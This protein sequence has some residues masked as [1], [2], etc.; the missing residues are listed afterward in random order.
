METLEY[1]TLCLTCLRP[2]KA[3]F[4]AC[5]NPFDTNFAFRILMHPKEARKGH[6]GTGRLTNFALNNCQIIIGED[7]DHNQEVQELLNS[8]NIFPMI[9]Y[10]GEESI[11]LS[12]SK[13]ETQSFENKTPLVFII[14][15]SWPCAKSM[16]RESKSLHS[17][18]RISFDSTIE[19]RFLIKHQPAKYC[20]STIESTY[21]LLGLLEQQ[22][23]ENIGAAKDSMIKA[24]DQLVKFHIKCASDPSMKHYDRKGGA[25]KDPSERKPSK[26]WEYREI[27]FD[28]KNYS[29]Q[30][31]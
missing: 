5:I 28:E 17:L 21:I 9:L 31:I 6:L 1:R 11:N 12:S 14:D 26:K 27:C 8:P 18:P 23:L 2:S 22:G 13:L 19:S 24:L 15:G 3:C 16:M 7:F 30:R 10:P 4:C 20:L 29:R 25:Y